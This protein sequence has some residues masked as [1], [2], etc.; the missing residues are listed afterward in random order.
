MVKLFTKY[1]NRVYIHFQ[2]FLL[3]A[4]KKNTIFIWPLIKQF[5]LMFLNP[6]SLINTD[7][8]FE[9]IIVVKAKKKML[10]VQLGK[11]N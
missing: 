3:F 9:V 5:I 8:W 10:P 6:H 11:S 1:W 7:F 4:E 2:P